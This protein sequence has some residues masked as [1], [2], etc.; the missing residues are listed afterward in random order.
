[1]ENLKSVGF[2]IAIVVV[3]LGVL[4]A[5]SVV[6]ASPPVVGCCLAA[7]AATRLV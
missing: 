2:V 4:M 3:I 1:M 7:V 5:L 6:P